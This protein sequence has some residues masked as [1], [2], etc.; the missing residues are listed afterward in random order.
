M[1]LSGWAASRSN[2]SLRI[3]AAKNDEGLFVIPARCPS[4]VSTGALLRDLFRG[5]QDDRAANIP[6][7]ASRAP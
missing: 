7:V 3:S 2:N 1:C 6:N 5:T 4:Q